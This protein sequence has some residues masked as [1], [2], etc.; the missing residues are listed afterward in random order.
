MNALITYKQANTKVMKIEVR[1]SGKLT[2]HIRRTP[3]GFYY[4][5]LG[6]RMVGEQFLSLESCKAVLETS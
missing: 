4:R 5:P 1:V 3:E 6:S 2:G